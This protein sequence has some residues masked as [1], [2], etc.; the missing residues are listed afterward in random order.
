MTDAP[1]SPVA[2]MHGFV[3]VFG[4][5]ALA[6]RAIQHPHDAEPPPELLAILDERDASAFKWDAD[7]LGWRGRVIT[8]RELA[9]ARGVFARGFGSCS[10]TEPIADLAALGWFQLDSGADDDATGLTS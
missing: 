5:A 7:S 10:F 2:V 4:A 9:R 6:W 3:N 8:A 1:D